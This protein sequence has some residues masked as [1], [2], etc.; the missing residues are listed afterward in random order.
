MRRSPP[1]R[2]QPN[3]GRPPASL[4]RPPTQWLGWLAIQAPVT[5]P[6]TAPST[7]ASPRPQR[8]AGASPARG[9]RMTWTPTAAAD[10]ASSTAPTPISEYIDASSG[11]ATL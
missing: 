5:V 3:S 11:E 2:D 8:S 6:S 9:K 4:R 10:A 1:L 7:N